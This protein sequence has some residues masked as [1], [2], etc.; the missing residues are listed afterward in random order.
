MKNVEALLST[1][2]KRDRDRPRTPSPG[3]ERKRRRSATPQERG[4]ADSRQRHLSPSDGGYEMRERGDNGITRGYGND[5][6][7]RRDSHKD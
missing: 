2:E 4:N 7:L 6:N 1:L 5:A 3:R